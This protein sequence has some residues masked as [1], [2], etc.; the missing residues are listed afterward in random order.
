LQLAVEPQNL[1]DDTVADMDV[2]VN[3]LPDNHDPLHQISDYVESI[4]ISLWDTA[5]YREFNAE[6]R[7][8]KN[9][10]PEKQL[11]FGPAL[12]RVVYRYFKFVLFPAHAISKS[13]TFFTDYKDTESKSSM[14]TQGILK[15]WS[16]V[17]LE[18]CTWYL[19]CPLKKPLSNEIALRDF[20][21][22]S[23]KSIEPA[24][25]GGATKD[26]SKN[27][28]DPKPKEPKRK[29]I[30]VDDNDEDTTVMEAP[31]LYS[32]D[33]IS[34]P[35]QPLAKRL[36]KD[37]TATTPTVKLATMVGFVT[38]PKRR[39]MSAT[40]RLPSRSTSSMEM[41]IN[42]SFV[43]IVEEKSLTKS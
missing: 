37:P 4:R 24:R 7:V 28:K 2:T 29:A 3:Y 9:N 32:A 12:K 19:D 36:R 11:K 30:I 38:P 14:Y 1:F 17:H 42:N 18:T 23:L 8:H 27:P 10:P 13:P 31:A 40:T 43:Q 41:I 33:V 35:V 16:P 15:S 34:S 6:K 21:E 39:S 25:P 26:T 22:P 20:L 5:F